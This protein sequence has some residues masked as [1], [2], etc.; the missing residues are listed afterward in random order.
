[1]PM[2]HRGP[3]PQTK[4]QKK[5]TEAKQAEDEKIIKEAHRFTKRGNN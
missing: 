3:A 2:K 1:M 5:A 4:E